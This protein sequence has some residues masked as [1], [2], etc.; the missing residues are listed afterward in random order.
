[1][2]KN[3]ITI[4]SIVTSIFIATSAYAAKCDFHST[5]TPWPLCPPN[6]S[7]CFDS[8]N[9][10]YNLGAFNPTSGDFSANLVDGSCNGSWKV[11]ALSSV[12][13]NYTLWATYQGEKLPQSCCTSKTPFTSQ[14]CPAALGCHATSYQADA[15]P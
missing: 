13:K 2:S 7:Q 1:M 5:P 12:N 6:P 15:R 8:N 9:K 10:A 4:F 11:C 14:K 3:V